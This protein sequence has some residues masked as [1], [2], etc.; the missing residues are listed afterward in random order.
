MRKL[1]GLAAFATALSAQTLTLREAEELAAKNHPQ[2]LAAE[3]G[4]LR[5]DQIT[6]ETKSAYLPSLNG[7]ITGAQ[8]NRD[9]RLGT[10]VLNASSLFSHFGSG[11][12][13]SQLITDSGR[14]SNLVA[15]SKLSAQAS[16]EDGRATR[17]NVIIGVD[18]A[19][20]QVLLSQQLVKVAEQTVKTRQTLVDQIS[21]LTKNKLKS[22]LDLSFVQVN[23]D[24]AQLML[25]RAQ[26][27]L[28]AAYANLGQAL[29]SQQAVHYQLTEPEKQA[30]PPT[31]DAESLIQQAFHNRPELASLNLQTRADQ[32]VVYAERDLKRPT[33]SL[34]A[35][36]GVLPYIVTGSASSSVANEY[37]SAGVNVQI[38]IFNGRLFTARQHAAEYQLQATQQ[39]AR[40]LQ[41]RIASDVRT[42]WAKTNTSF[43]AIATS[44]R[45]LKQATMA[46]DLAQGRYDLGL[47]S[48]VELTQAQL[49]LTQAQVEN[50]DAKYEYE[51][52]YAVLQY[53]LGLVSIAP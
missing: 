25:L 2:V 48:I 33:V 13:L 17:Y 47:S 15:N 50:V 6:L 12:V 42:A 5:A 41:D 14:T 27:Q 7:E 4:S 53:T 36:A 23:L 20:Y 10:G 32:K 22:N 28:T 37:E 21:E 1:V 51:E 19:Y 31:S 35:V 45:L 39:R 38:P 11:I 46:L 9:A 44:E 3:A 18:Q 52:A 49:G 24:E 30:E 43:Q 29:G 16:R 8:A 26:D 40:D 34:T